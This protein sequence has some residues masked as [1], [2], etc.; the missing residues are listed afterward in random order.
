MTS[1]CPNIAICGGQEKDTERCRR[2]PV[3]FDSQTT[4][5][6]RTLARIRGC[7]KFYFG[8]EKV[9]WFCAGVGATTQNQVESSSRPRAYGSETN[10]RSLTTAIVA[11]SINFDVS[12]KHEAG[13]DLVVARPSRRR[14]EF[15]HALRFDS[16]EAPGDI[17]GGLFYLTTGM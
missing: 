14:L 10:F 17:A 12:C 9:T 2:T 1:Q 13:F 3:F 11:G 15:A 5:E 7:G 6:R 4:P 16:Y 8:S